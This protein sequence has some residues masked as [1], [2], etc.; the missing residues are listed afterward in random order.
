MNVTKTSA[1]S[2]AGQRGEHV[3][4]PSLAGV[5]VKVGTVILCSSENK[6]C[7][8]LQGEPQEAFQKLHWN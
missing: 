7:L 2:P 8:T 6:A 4:A 5:G 1:L 3:P